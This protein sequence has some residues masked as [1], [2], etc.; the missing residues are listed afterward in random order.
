[1]SKLLLS[2]CF[3]GALL[4]ASTL[5]VSTA[6]VINGGPNPQSRYGSASCSVADS[7]GSE[8]DA[9][10][11]GGWTVSDSISGPMWA[12]YGLNTKGPSSSAP[13]QV[14]TAEVSVS[15]QTRMRFP[16]TGTRSGFPQA[17][18]TSTFSI[19]LETV[20]PQRW[21]FLEILYPWIESDS[22]A[23]GDFHGTFSFSLG[24]VWASCL[25]AN[26]FPLLNCGPLNYF[27]PYIIPVEIGNGVPY[28]LTISETATSAADPVFQFNAGSMYSS[29]NV[30]FLEADGST[31][32][33]MYEAPEPAS[34]GLFA[35]AFAGGCLL[36]RR[37]ALGY[38]RSLYK[39]DNHT[40]YFG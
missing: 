13:F 34:Y 23:D 14:L 37:K 7:F 3:T 25:G 39:E 16:L 12:P 21:G 5:D 9:S 36:R 15:A 29:V 38:S 33:P 31:R 4:S 32:V 1:M 8:A 18:G 27:R 26:N 10:A 17:T 6:C 30:Q 40:E 22:S 28:I 11:S 24:P 19:P 2:L 35:V 20:G